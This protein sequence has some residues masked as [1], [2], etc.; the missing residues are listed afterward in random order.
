MGERTILSDPERVLVTAL[1]KHE[2]GLQGV[3]AE[4]LFA[5]LEREHGYDRARL[6]EAVDELQKEQFLEV[7]GTSVKLTR[8]GY[9]CGGHDI[10]GLRDLP[11]AP[12]LPI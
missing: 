7:S 6:H 12:F 3:D 5:T 11:S 9:L 4:T 8:A 1:S 10:C 2:Q